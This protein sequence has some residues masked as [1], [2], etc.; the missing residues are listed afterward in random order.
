MKESFKLNMD[1]K[2]PEK[3]G[4]KLERNFKN[5]VVTY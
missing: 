2:S 1:Q 5:L 3:F 4:K